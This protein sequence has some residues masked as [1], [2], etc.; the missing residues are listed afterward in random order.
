MRTIYA[1]QLQITPSDN[2]SATDVFAD[3]VSRIGRWVDGKYQRAWNTS[4]AMPTDGSTIEPL[5]GHAL[6]AVSRVTHDAGLFTLD[7]THPADGDPSTAWVTNC[8]V[9]RSGEVVQIA[10]L[11]RISTTRTVLRP[12]RFDL[13]RPR[14]VTDLLEDYRTLIDGWPVPTEPERLESPRVQPYVEEVLLNPARNL[15]VILVSPDAWDG[16]LFVD[17]AQLFQR[18]RG[19]A[20]VTVLADERAAFK[21][22][23]VVEKPLS[24]YCGAV[25]VYWPGF[26]LNDNR[27]Q[28]KLFSAQS[29]QFHEQEGLPLGDHLFRVFSAVAS[30][31]YTEGAA[32]RNARQAFADLERK[33]V[34]ELREQIKAGSV[35]K[36]N[37]EI[38][39]LEA[40][41]KIDKLTDEL[42]QV[43]ANLAAQQAA[44]AEVQQA[45]A[46]AD[47]GPAEAPTEEKVR[48]SSVLDAV[49]Q[50]KRD[51]SGPLVF[52]DSALESAKDSPYKDPERV[53]EL[54]RA[55]ALVA[56]EW[57]K[58]KGSL[59]QSWNHAL[60]ALGF[61]LRDQVSMTSRGKYGDQY[62]FVYKGQ[63][64][65]FEKH[66]TIGAKQADKCLSVHWYRDDDDL[67]LAIGHCGRHLSN[68]ST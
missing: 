38:Q 26:T 36:E 44:W 24:C 6:G 20:H 53:Y 47:S 51:F 31:R 25:R 63:R 58:N 23:D 68:T 5:Q 18:V 33:K 4:V 15:P 28:H 46:T 9:G 65:L 45:M 56:E 57:R 39:L 11:L 41:E 66:I 50:A 48:F 29:I 59:G 40:L 42:D 22:T 62:R 60:S 10:V 14:L 37:L 49:E 30:Y 52:L 3:L 64:R 34:D 27:F 2:Q 7:W 13:G 16:K 61:D 67:V 17:P 55:L 12:V 35:E 54:F 21:L 32:I 19:F 43:K 8:I 1:I